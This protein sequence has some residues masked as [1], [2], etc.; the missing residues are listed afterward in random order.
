MDIN[1][2]RVKDF[3]VAAKQSIPDGPFEPDENTRYLRVKLLLEE[4]S[5]HIK[6]LGFNLYKVDPDTGA[7]S[8]VDLEFLTP[9]NELPFDLE[10]VVD[11]I[12][13]VKVIVDGTALA[14][15]VDMEP[16]DEAV[17]DSNMA[18]FGPGGYSRADGKWVK[19]PD[20][21]P[22]DIKRILS[23]QSLNAITRQA[24]ELGLY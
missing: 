23:R 2:K 13:D 14:C 19:P 15:G 12:A 5:E 11:G 21:Q 9:K 24:E 4:V 22:P 20:W 8:F 10:E 17:Y 1:Q 7:E 18:K 3:M 6:G 16:I